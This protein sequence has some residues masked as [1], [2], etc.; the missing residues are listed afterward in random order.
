MVVTTAMG[1]VPTADGDRRRFPLR[2]AVAAGAAA[3]LA[4]YLATG[5]LLLVDGGPGASV[6]VEDA[7]DGGLLDSLRTVGLVFLETH[8]V[9][10][11]VDIG[12]HAATADLLS[13]LGGTVPVA[14]YHLLPVA[15]IAGVAAL[16]VTAAPFRPADGETS[17]LLGAGLVV[18][19]LPPTLLGLVVFT[20]ARGTVGLAPDPLTGLLFAGFL[21][22]TACGML[23]G[24]LAWRPGDEGLVG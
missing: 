10:T 7:T 2:R 18:G 17:A 14:A 19:Y 12:R 23:G 4:G 22:P 24:T 16:F 6:T 5:A 13:E 8:L 20:T 15:T 21:Y 3:F 9:A 1:R 11:N